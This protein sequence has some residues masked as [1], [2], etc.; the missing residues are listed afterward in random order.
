[1]SDTV[2]VAALR[3]M[4]AEYV[5]GVDIFSSALR[6]HLGPPGMGIT[7]LEILL[8]RAGGGIE[9]ADC[10]IRPQLDG[11]SYLRFG[12]RKKFIA[13]GEQATREKLPEICAQIS[14]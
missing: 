9:K 2:P 8:Q 4:G 11:L 7:A 13:L 3:R 1:M 12:L 10:L 14:K 5:I 6:P